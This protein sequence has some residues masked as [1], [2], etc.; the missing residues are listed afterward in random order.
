MFQFTKRKC[1]H[2][3]SNVRVLTLP[4]GCQERDTHLLVWP[5]L[6]LKCIHRSIDPAVSSSAQQLDTPR[7]LSQGGQT[8]I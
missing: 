6:D 4:V 5:K 8:Q 3:V 7:R 2:P 1:Q